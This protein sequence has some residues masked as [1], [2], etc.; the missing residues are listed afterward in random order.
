MHMQ[1]RSKTLPPHCTQELVHGDDDTRVQ[2][3]GQQRGLWPHAVRHGGA[4]RPRCC[5]TAGAQQCKVSD[6]MFCHAVLSG[7]V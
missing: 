7:V 4:L 3:R 5:G 6:S 2:Q 1:L